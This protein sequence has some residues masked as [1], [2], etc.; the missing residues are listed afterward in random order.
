MAQKKVLIGCPTSDRKAYCLQRFISSL[1]SITYTNSDILFVD[2]SSTQNYAEN[3]RKY[4]YEVVHQKTSGNH[5]IEHIIQNRNI[6]IKRAL[7]KK[8]DYLLFLDTDIE[9][10]EDL[11]E[12]LLKHDKPIT[13]S[14]YLSIQTVKGKNLIAPVLMDFTSV[15]GFVQHIPLNKVINQDFFE[16][17]ACG[18]GCCLIKTEVLEKVP[19]RYNK[20]YGGGEDFLFC[21]DARDKFGYKTYVD[22]S[23]KCIHIMEDRDI[24]FP[25]ASISTSI[26]YSRAQ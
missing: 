11:I 6:I 25:M 23:I 4:G 22:T 13:S 15:K 8:Y 3:I 16:V 17:A 21:A 24:D 2:N 1:K 9:F 7:E 12:R 26:T 5:V 10:P 20:E 19:L 18:F 14:V